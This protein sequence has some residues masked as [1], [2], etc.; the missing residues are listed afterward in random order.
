M[1]DN[2]ERIGEILGAVGAVGCFTARPLLPDG[3]SDLYTPAPW[4]GKPDQ[5]GISRNDR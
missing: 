1:I 2:L 5:R 4:K 3:A